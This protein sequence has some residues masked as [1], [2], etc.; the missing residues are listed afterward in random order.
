MSV[1]A[2]R[3]TREREDRARGTRRRGLPI[4][5]VLGKLPR[6]TVVGVAPDQLASAGGTRPSPERRTD[7]VASRGTFQPRPTSITRRQPWGGG[8]LRA[9]RF[10]DSK[11]VA[12]HTAQPGSTALASGVHGSRPPNRPPDLGEC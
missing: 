5:A 10:R 6:A 7:Q 3:P 8:A 9:V 2:G 1:L 4:G 12:S 11:R